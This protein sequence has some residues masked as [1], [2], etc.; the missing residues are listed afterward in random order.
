[1]SEL[2]SGTVTFLFT[3]LEGSTRLWEEHTEG[4]RAALARHDEILHEA[5]AAQGGQVVKAT[6]DGVHAVFPVAEDAVAAAVAA[7]MG[8][9]A[10]SWAEVGEL[11][12]RMG[13][14]TGS[15]DRRGGDYYGP[16]LNRAA[17]LMAIAHGGQI[18]C[19]QA[20][21]D[22][23]R[24]S[25]PDLTGLVD[26]GDHQ[27][28]DLGRVERVFQVT[29]PRL[30]GEFAPLRSMDPAAPSN[31]PLPRSG[32]IG[33]QEELKKLTKLLDRSRVITLTGTG[34]VG[35]TRLAVQAADSLVSRF[36]DGVWFVDLAPV[37][38][39][40]LVAT[41][42]ATAMRL[43]DRRQGTVEDALVAAAREWHALIVL[44]NCEHVIETAAR[45]ADLITQR[46]SDVTILATSR[47]PLGVEGERI[48]GVGPLRV[49]PADADRTPEELLEAEAVRLFVERASAA[50]EGFTL[51]V[52]NAAV[53]ASACRRLDGIPLAIELAAA[54]MQAMSPQSIL[55]RLDERFRLLSQGRRTALAR[56]QTLRAAVDWSYGLLEPVEQL[57]F[58]RLSVFAGGFSLEAAEAVVTGEGVGDDVVLDTLGSLVAKSIVIVDESAL[59]VR[60]R[61]LETLREYGADRLEEL[62][63]PE[64]LRIRHAD[65]CVALAEEAGPHILGIDD[66][67]WARRLEGE[68]DNLHAALSWVRDHDPSKLTRLAHALTHFWRRQRQFREA[69]G[70]MEDAL[71]TDPGMSSR[72]RADIA[73]QAG[74]IAINLSQVDRGQAF[75]RQSLESSNQAGEEPLAYALIALALGALVSNC[76]ADA[77]SS[78]EQALQRASAEGEPYRLAEC[79][80]HA[81]IMISMISDDPRA[82]ELADRSVE[83]ARPLA[84]EYLLALTLEAAGLARYRTD[85]TAAIALLDESMAVAGDSYAA[86]TD[87]NSLLQGNRS[88][89]SP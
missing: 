9:G 7:Q 13:L 42:V 22:L 84:N 76:P 1:M 32:F 74:W 59:D 58:A 53:V 69:I 2:P 52:D 16:T 15:A 81:G 49:P 43:P 61:M 29:H 26:L 55:E 51:N 28:R 17:R 44:D 80:A 45:L 4:M 11:R 67:A 68:H 37:D 64:R 62:D 48:L 89:Q 88:R 18:V 20:A 8:L 21:A 34:G 56:H 31:L 10:E 46:C 36:G 60:Y 70:W 82:M 39:G 38:N 41:A 86:V 72:V 33:R 47:E 54:R 85:P 66:G 78:A 19:S 79:L 83:V 35:K 50:R 63:D 14:H 24:D 77:R 25:L 30:R 27:L 5:V 12:V 73:A 40:G 65:W 57:V 3:D 23:V 6:G 71:T 75:L 87:M